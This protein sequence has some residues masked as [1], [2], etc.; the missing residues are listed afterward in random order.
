[1]NLEEYFDRLRRMANPEPL[2]GPHANNHD[3]DD[4]DESSDSNHTGGH[5]RHLN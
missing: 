2:R 1:M 3:D 4:D 5:I